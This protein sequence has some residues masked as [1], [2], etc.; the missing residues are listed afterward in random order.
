ML[1]VVG[2]FIRL[3]ITLDMRDKH[4]HQGETLPED[5]QFVEDLAGKLI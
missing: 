3:I 1:F 5:C 2:E 4:R